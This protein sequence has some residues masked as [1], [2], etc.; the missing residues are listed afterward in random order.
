MFRGK[1]A[2]K[3]KNEYINKIEVNDEFYINEWIKI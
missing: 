2:V 3:Y 1:C